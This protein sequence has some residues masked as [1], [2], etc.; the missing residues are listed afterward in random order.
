MLRSFLISAAL[1]FATPSA[2]AQEAGTETPPAYAPYEFL[3]GEWDAGPAGGAVS[4]IDRFSW[5]PRRA[6]IWQSVALV[7]S[8]GEHLHFEGPM[9]WN[10]ATRRLDFLF[11]IEPNSLAQERGEV[12][13]GENGAIVRDV[14]LTYADGRQATFRHIIRSTGADTAEA[15]MMR[16][17]PQG[18]WAPEFPG[19][20]RL[21][22]RRRSSS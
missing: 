12:S 20:D 1:L 13:V 11:A 4:F 6:Y 5:G 18:G 15:S 22:M 8:N 3:I 9:M 14:T 7:Q 10:A 21:L 16:R 2:L 19:S 17:T